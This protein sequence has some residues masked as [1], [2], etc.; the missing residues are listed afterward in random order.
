MASTATATNATQVEWDYHA[1]NAMSAEELLAWAHEHYGNRAG[2]V[3]SFQDT[4][5]VMIDLAS[6]AAPGM[7][8]LTV[9]TLR[10]HDE[11]YALI[12]EV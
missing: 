1:L 9:D 2:I 10:L 5:T 3:T 12:D 7:R 8:V 4:G 11:T 6:K